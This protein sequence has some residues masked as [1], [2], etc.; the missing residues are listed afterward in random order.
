MSDSS[1]K[2]AI[3][4]AGVAG[5]SAGVYG[6]LNGFETVIYEKNSWIGG[7]CSGWKRNGYT[8]DNCLH[9]L[10]GTREG[11]PDREMWMELG[12][13]KSDE[14][15][16][17]RDLFFASSADGQTVTLWRD[18]NRTRTEMLQISPEDKTEIESF[19][20]CV[21]LFAG[22]LKISDFSVKEVYRS[23][24]DFNSSLNSSRFEFAKNFVQYLNT[25]SLELAKRF[26]CRAIQSLFIDFMAKE[27]ESY[28][29]MLAYSF[30]VADNGDLPQGGS[31]G[32]V[33]NLKERY[34]SLG[35]KIYTNSPVKKV[36]ID[37]KYK[38]KKLMPQDFIKNMNPKKIIYKHSTGLLLES[39]ETVTADYVICASDLKFTYQNLLKNK[40]TPRSLKKVYA[41]KAKRKDLIYSSFH[42]A[43]AVDGLFEAVP[44][45]LSIDCNPI[46]IGT[47][48]YKRFTI[49]NYRLYGDF[50]APE[51]KTVLQ[52]SIP[53]YEKD[54][55]Y[56][57]KYSNHKK[58]YDEI[59]K[60][61]ALRIMKEIENK[62]PDYKK[63]LSILDVW[64][65]YSYYRLNNDYL[66]AYMRYM[67]TPFSMN[68][69]LPSAI[70]GLDNVFLASHYLRYP[71]GLP[72]AAMTGRDAIEEIKKLELQKVTKVTMNFLKKESKSPQK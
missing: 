70:K 13:L 24:R 4:G 7:S 17:K 26:K 64:T 3:V 2:I 25:S 29:L 30:F 12:V 42:V 51:G 72:T 66:G 38:V 36:L 59:K 63:R 45:T 39:N 6:Q 68:A 8:I 22:L 33:Q 60:L 23:L 48:T 32:M 54:F 47:Q 62:Y 65:P 53:Q 52:V 10:T 28:W 11:S 15:L 58:D 1:K 57:D 31:M 46:K 20:D 49:K 5:L 69:F 19:L 40:Y 71:G 44:D 41:H 67:T 34:E 18:I 55:K 21:E 43:F 61:T 56:W 27:Y 9:W 50:I 16:V 37:K 14:P 35:G